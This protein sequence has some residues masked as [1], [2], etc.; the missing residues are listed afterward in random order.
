MSFQASTWAL[1]QKVGSPSAKCVLLALANYAD[2]YG[3]CWPSQATLSRETEQS[4]DTVQRRLRDLEKLGLIYRRRQAKANGWRGADAIVLLVDDVAR[5]Y[6]EHHGF[7]AEAVGGAADDVGEAMPET[8]GGADGA[9]DEIPTS[10]PDETTS[11]EP[12]PQSAV[13]AK[14]ANCG[15]GQSRNCAAAMNNQTLNPIPPLNP[16]LPQASPVAEPCGEAAAN[17][18][19]RSWRVDWT[20]F[21]A[22]WIWDSG[23]TRDRAMRAMQRLSA[24]DRAAAVKWAADHCRA[25][26]AKKTRSV[27]ARKYLSERV[28]ADLA[29]RGGAGRPARVF[30]RIG[31][32]AWEAWEAEWRRGAGRGMPASARMFSLEAVIDGE[33][34]RGVWRDTLYPPGHD[35]PAA[36]PAVGAGFAAG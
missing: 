20:A 32:P 9:Y 2:E 11:C 33:R 31:S 5:A 18:R 35:P 1:A 12:K 10:A 28:F 25:V 22:A 7:D 17:D 16:P 6:A 4:L 13:L 15:L 36:G 14:A 26:A 3:E 30:V 19:L 8:H 29:R 27:S 21:E 34:R 24:E 23:E